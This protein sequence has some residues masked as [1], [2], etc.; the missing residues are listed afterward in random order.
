MVGMQSS[1]ATVEISIK[2]P[3]KKKSKNGPPWPI[4]TLPKYLH[5]GLHG[6]MTEMLAHQCSQLC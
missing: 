1:S 6:D 3:Q 2:V 5:K 4:C